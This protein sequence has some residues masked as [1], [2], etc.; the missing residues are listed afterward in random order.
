[1]PAFRKGIPHAT[2]LAALLVAV[3]GFASCRSV[4][5]VK[6]EYDE[7]VY[8]ELDGSATV[9][10]NA[11]VPALVALRG[12]PFNVDSRARLDRNDVRTFFESP[13]AQVESVTTSRRDNRRYVHVRLDVPDIRRL[14]EAVPFAW[15]RYS[16]K[17][18]DD[19][20]RFQQLVG[21]SAARDVGDVG[22]TGQE[23]V[24]FRLHLP[25]RV[26]F[27]SARGREIERGNIIRW[28]QSLA[29][30]LHG[31]PV[32]IEVHMETDSILLQTLT[33]FGVT[34]VLALTTFVLAIWWVM[35]R[36][37][38]DVPGARTELPG[39]PS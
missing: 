39:T 1:M 6:Y 34:I 23:M 35:R 12:A 20:A 15:S 32:A 2:G 36:K 11:S 17:G 10:V 33:L 30:R 4:L 31:E 24:A 7:E 19:L 16:F 25:S 8:L 38:A 28:E 26:P 27:H 13:V 29:D 37:G 21:P 9:Y 14:H 3:L 5:T 18:D 22:W